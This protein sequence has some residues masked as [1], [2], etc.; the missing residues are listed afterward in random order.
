M[1]A[2]L[3]MEGALTPI[4]LTME[5][6][7]EAVGTDTFLVINK[8]GHVYTQ[9]EDAGVVLYLLDKAHHNIFCGTK[10]LSGD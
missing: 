3:T 10:V 1:A 5:G 8:Y 7:V 2:R 9:I 6:I 4:P